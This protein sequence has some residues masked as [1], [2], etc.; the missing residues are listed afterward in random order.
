MKKIQEGMQF[1]KD[2]AEGDGCA[3]YREH[4]AIAAYY[5]AEQRGFRP[6]H[7]LDDWIKAQQYI[8]INNS[9]GRH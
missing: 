7:E 3:K 8:E 6:G 4:V 5:L 2:Q 9:Q 1:C